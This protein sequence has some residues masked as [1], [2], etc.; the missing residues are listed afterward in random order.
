MGGFAVSCAPAIT[1]FIG[2]NVE[3]RMQAML[4]MYEIT[5]T[6]SN[7]F[8]VPILNGRGTPTGVEAFRVL[9]TGIRPYITTG[10]AHKDSGV[11]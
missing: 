2:G 10:I 6:E 11:G 7:R 9:E 1:D 8:S 4:D 3:S 5:V